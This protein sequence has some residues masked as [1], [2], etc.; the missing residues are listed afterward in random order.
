[1]GRWFLRL[2]YSVKRYSPA[3]VEA[4][5]IRGRRRCRHPGSLLRPF[6]TVFLAIALHRFRS[7]VPRPRLAT[8]ASVFYAT[9]RY[10]RLLLVRGVTCPRPVWYATASAQPISGSP[11]VFKSRDTSERTSPTPG[12]D[13]AHPPRK[14]AQ[15]TRHGLTRQSAWLCLSGPWPNPFS[16]G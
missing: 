1:S 15:V 16:R 14:K 3:V 8:I 2:T 11:T 9:A 7:T 6:D 13:T 12:P 5:G 10:L 4:G